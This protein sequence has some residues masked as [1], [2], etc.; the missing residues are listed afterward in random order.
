MSS[1][2]ASWL[3]AVS[4]IGAIVHAH[5]DPPVSF[6]IAFHDESTAYRDAAMFVLPG[7]QTTM[8]AVGGPAGDYVARTGDGVLVQTATRAW[9]WEAPARPGAYGIHFDGPSAKDVVVLH[10]FVLVPA[11]KVK[12][13]LLNGY[14]IGT[15]P[16]RPLDGNAMYR[17]PRGF[18]EVTKDN[19]KTKLSPHF[20]LQQF[21]CKEGPAEQFPKYVVLNERLPLKLEAIVERL[22]ARGVRVDTLHIMSGYRTPYYNRTI[23]DVQYSEHQWGAAADIFVDRANRGRMDDLNGDGRVDVADSKFLYD[24]IDALTNEPANRRFEGGLGFYPGTRA[25]PPFVHVDVRGTKARW[26]G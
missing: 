3:A 26:R 6:A 14:R 5:G 7:S 19:Q 24:Q 20:T 13:G 1:W 10:A 8:T 17:P 18:V 21:V 11:S 15:Y 22:N 16:L 4:L 25:H 12:D 9:R 23:G 2:R